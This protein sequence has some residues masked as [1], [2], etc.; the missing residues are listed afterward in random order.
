MKR[1]Q[2]ESSIDGLSCLSRKVRRFADRLQRF[3]GRRTVRHSVELLEVRALLTTPPVLAPISDVTLLAGS[4]LQIPLNAMDA[5]GQPL[6]YSASSSNASVAALIHEGNRSLR[7]NV[8]SFGSMVFELF[9]DRVPRVTSQLITLAEAGYYSGSGFHF[10]E[11]GE[12]LQGGKPGGDPLDNTPSPLGAVDDQFHVDLQHNRTGLLSLARDGFDDT[13]DAEFLITEGTQRSF[14]VQHSV[15]GLLV[16]GEGVREAISNVSTNA[17]GR[18]DTPVVISSVDVFVDEQNGVLM[19]AAPEGYSGTAMVTVT[20]TDSDGNSDQQ[21]FSVTVQPDTVDS[22]PWLADVPRLRTRVDTTISVPLAAVDVEG[23]AS[24]FFDETRLDMFGLAV[25]QRADADLSYSVDPVTG[26]TQITP[27]NGL[28]GTQRLTVATAIQ[29]TAVDYQVLPVEIL[30]TAASLALS[31]SNWIGGDAAGDGG[32]DTIRL[33]RT[34]DQIEVFIDGDLSYVAT[35]DS[36]TTLTID[37]SSDDSTL[38]VDLSGGNPVP[39]GGLVFSGSPASLDA[40]LL[41]S[42]ADTGVVA[43]ANPGSFSIGGRSVTLSSVETLIENPAESQWSFTFGVEDDVI[44]FSDD[45]VPGDG[46]SRIRNEATGFHFEFATPAS[47]SIFTGDGADSVA[48]DEA[49]G[50]APNA[51]L[52]GGDG[53]DTLTGGAGDDRLD[54]ERGSDV[55]SGRAGNDFLMG[56]ADGDTL[57]GGDGD[58]WLAG[59]AGKDDLSGGPGN[60]QL[61]GQGTTGDTLRG[62]DGDDTLDG[63]PG[64]DIVIESVAGNVTATTTTL[65]GRGND[66]LTSIERINLTGSAGPDQIDASGFDVPGFTEVSLSGAGGNDSLIG[67]NGNDQLRGNGGNDTLISG[68]GRDRLYGGSGKDRL[69]GGE[70]DDK[71]LGNGGSGDWLSGGPGDDLIKGGSGI[72]RLVE[73]ADVDFVLTDVRLTGLGAD[74]LSQL[75]AASLTGGPSDN[76]INASGFTSGFVLLFGLGGNDSLIGGSGHDRLEGGTGNDTLRG[77]AGVDTLKGGAGDD[78]LA[79]NADSD[80]LL[81]QD[82]NDSLFGG[83][84]DDILSGGSGADLIVGNAGDDQINGDADA[85]TLVGG[86]G[87]G[88]RDAGDTFDDLSEVIDDYFVSNPLPDWLI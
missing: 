49:D 15:A 25:P 61:F 5:E 22:P 88:V 1:F 46:I 87:D 50:E 47:L 9:E 70:G 7:I 37:G 3:P 19:L 60:D 21:S 83:D 79:G 51:T 75:E 66:V 55:L 44:V 39:A 2:T 11:D 80:S 18:P 58:D 71:V 33:V 53:N 62:G 68:L 69:F 13:G 10:V 36:L 64:N 28:T 52:V 6:S 14:D 81:G 63:G 16:D 72:D 65:D 54:G 76:V 48:I 23:D 42:N 43:G 73:V 8:D 45:E 38:I 74:R 77:G 20:V 12:R 82:G 32:A 40:F 30:A 34:A 31:A 4:P 24:S 26:L 29:T 35:L 85:D 17:T 67:S 86:D 27:M 57:F 56:K 59:S 41:T 84:L 78:G